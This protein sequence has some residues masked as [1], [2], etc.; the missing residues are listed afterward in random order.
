MVNARFCKSRWDR[1]TTK[2]QTRKTGS[3]KG[4]TDSHDKIVCKEFMSKT[5]KAVVKRVFEG[6]CCTL[7]NS[8][9]FE[10]SFSRVQ[11][12]IH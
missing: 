4:K 5:K 9:V 10:T 12:I 3:Q 2:I 1:K 11:G 8:L 6:F 7:V